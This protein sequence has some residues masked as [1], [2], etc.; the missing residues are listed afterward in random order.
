MAPVDGLRIIVGLKI[1]IV[2]AIT[3]LTLLPTASTVVVCVCVGT[4][5]YV[6]M[7]E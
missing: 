3:L 1:F 2:L 4:S 5:V 7:S 6:C